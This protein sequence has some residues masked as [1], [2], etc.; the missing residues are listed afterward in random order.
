MS[1]LDAPILAADAEAT[2][3][4]AAFLLTLEQAKMRLTPANLKTEATNATLDATLRG[5]EDAKNIARANPF[6]LVGVALIFGAVAAR[7][8][9]S[10]LLRDLWVVAKNA[11]RTYRTKE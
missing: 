4:R 10:A 8:P 2:E 1:D 9:L 5:I 7:K 6:K 11:Y 3:R